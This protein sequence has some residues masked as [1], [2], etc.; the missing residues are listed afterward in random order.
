MSSSPRT[1]HLRRRRARWRQ[2]R[3]HRQVRQGR[4]VHQGRGARRVRARA[5]STRRTACCWIAQG[6]LLVA[7]RGNSRVQVFDQDGKFIARVE[8]V[9]AAERHLPRSRRDAL[10]CGFTVRR[11]EYESNTE[12]RHSHR[13]RTRRQGPLLRSGSGADRPRGRWRARRRRGRSR[14]HHLCRED[15]CRWLL[16][17]HQGNDHERRISSR[18]ASQARSTSATATGVRFLHAAIGGRTAPGGAAWRKCSNAARYSPVA[19]L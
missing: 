11:A 9:R 16:S 19:T 14:R 4:E 10:R 13:R 7:D 6:R 1:A 15:R 12:A 18:R 8:T 5:S 2:Q 17:I 3:A